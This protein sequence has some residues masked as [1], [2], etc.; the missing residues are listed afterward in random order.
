MIEVPILKE[1]REYKAKTIGSLTT[2]ELICGIGATAG[3]YLMYGI[4][5]WAGIENPQGFLMMLG[6]IPGVMFLTKPYGLKFEVYLKSAFVDSVLAPT[7]RIYRPENP[8]YEL[9]SLRK[10]KE[11]DENQEID[12]GEKPEKIKKKKVKKK[13][14]SAEWIAGR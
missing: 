7:I 11:D 2:R 10:T 4:Q 5:K 13:E 1:I 9:L 3:A 6:A 14:L 8:Y 12:I